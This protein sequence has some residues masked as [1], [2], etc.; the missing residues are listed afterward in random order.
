MRKIL[1]HSVLVEKVRV[2]NVEEKIKTLDKLGD[3]CSHVGAYRTAVKFYTSEVLII[4][5]CTHTHTHTHILLHQNIH[6]YAR[7]HAHQLELAET[8]GREPRELSA[9][10][11]S[12]ACCHSDCKQHSK[13]LEMYKKELQY[14]NE[15]NPN[16]VFT[17]THTHTRTHTHHSSL[18]VHTMRRGKPLSMLQ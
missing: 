9:I 17:H 6:T 11:V 3:L 15:D 16:E 2:E 4:E 18:Y 13:A 8:H 12:V 10:C 5:S 1:K 7:T 14:W